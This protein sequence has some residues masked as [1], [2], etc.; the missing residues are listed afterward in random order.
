MAK[1]RFIFDENY[2]KRYAKRD[3]TRWLVIGVSVLVLVVIIILVMLVSRKEKDRPVVPAVTK[4]ELKEELILEAGSLLP[5][6]V[7]YFKEYENVDMTDVK[8]TYP[9]EFEVSYD[10]SACS[11]L[12]LSEMELAGDNV[13]Y[14][15]YDCVSTI[16][17]TPATYGITI[18]LLDKEYTVRLVVEDTTAPVVI[19]QN[20]E[21]YEGEEYKLD[22]FVKT[23]YDIS[24]DCE[25]NYYTEDKTEEGTI[26]DY[27]KFTDAGTYTIKLIATDKYENVSKPVEA[28]LVIVKPESPLYV[29]TFNS[30]GGSN[31][32]NVLVE[33]G[34]T[35]TEPEVPTRLGYTFAGWYYGNTKYDFNTLI[36]RN[37]TLVARWEKESSGGGSG[38]SQG[39]STITNAITSVAINYKT[40]YVYDGDSKTVSATVKYTGNV[41]TTVT[42][43]S[44]DSSI[45]TVSGGKI[46]G[47]K[48]GSTIVTATAGGK[49]GTVEVIV[50]EK[51]SAIGCTYGDASYNTSYILSVNLIQNN[52]AVNPNAS[53]NEVATVAAN[54]YTKVVQ[55]LNSKGYSTDESHFAYKQSYLNVKN[56]SGTGLVGIQITITIN[57]VDA[58]GNLKVSQYIIKP[59]GSRQFS[60]NEI[61][62]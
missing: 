31:V 40:I 56:N 58:N 50:K 18:S 29:V 20:K 16:L 24:D 9:E 61:G 21:I 53:Y 32:D 11:A 13:D 38:T 52:C 36:T 34:K 14:T 26:I 1:K 37:I 41:D 23:C 27:S 7:D 48:V 43:S 39:G 3:K 10:V 15:K 44:K 33:E 47:V 22:D 19:T 25:V 6:V 54:D 62:L 42:W 4:Y 60:K 51:S 35:V 17:S 8:I 55:T 28:T 30:N 49:S 12:V 46:T 57:L 45:A 5:E 59:D 2:I